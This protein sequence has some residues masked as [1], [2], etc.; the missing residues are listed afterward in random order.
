MAPQFDRELRDLL[1]VAGCTLVRQGKGSHEIWHSPL[2]N[3][4]FAVPVGIPSRHTANAILRQA[5]L[6]KAF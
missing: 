5:G 6:P 3:R 2:T 4:N 1:R